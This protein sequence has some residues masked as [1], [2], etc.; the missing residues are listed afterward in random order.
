LTA[1]LQVRKL[2]ED[3]NLRLIL[4]VKPHATVETAQNRASISLGIYK[5]IANI[6]HCTSII[7][8]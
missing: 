1:D 8:N 5:L 2:V 6:V 3:V 4:H 7:V